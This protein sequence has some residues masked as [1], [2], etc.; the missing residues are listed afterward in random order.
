[1]CGGMEG[2]VDG[3]GKVWEGIEVGKLGSSVRIP[4]SLSTP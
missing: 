1:M 3:E 2:D 4:L